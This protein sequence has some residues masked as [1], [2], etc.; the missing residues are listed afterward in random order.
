MLG[1]RKA[2]KEKGDGW[3]GGR[4]WLCGEEGSEWVLRET[5]KLARAVVGERLHWKGGVEKSKL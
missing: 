1:L 4:V 3:E 2:S 5:E